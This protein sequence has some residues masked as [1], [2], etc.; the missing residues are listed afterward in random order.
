[1][2]EMGSSP[3]SAYN[4]SEFLCMWFCLIFIITHGQGSKDYY[5]QSQ[6]EEIEI[7][8]AEVTSQG[9]YQV[10]GMPNSKANAISNI[11]FLNLVDA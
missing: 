10:S 2:K 5:S 11:L 3:L 1:M 8:R 4:V 7:H 9:Q 6:S